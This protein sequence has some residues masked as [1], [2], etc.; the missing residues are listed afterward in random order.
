M[1]RDD[2]RRAG[3]PHQGSLARL[4]T[5]LR[6][7]PTTHLGFGE[8]IRRALNGGLSIT[9]VDMV[10]QLKSLTNAGLLVQ[11]PS[12][13][14]EPLFDTVPRPHFH[15]VYDEASEP[16]D[17]DVS[18]ETLLAILRQ[19]FKEQPDQVEVLVRFRRTSSFLGDI[20]KEG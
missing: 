9:P 3:L 15:L 10:R 8:I 4:L 13:G 18:P 19:A 20:A 7:A 16:A 2:L 1:L 14:A 6:D 11:L 17:L 5:V 12:T